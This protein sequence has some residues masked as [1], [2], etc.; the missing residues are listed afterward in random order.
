[1]L[2]GFVFS[3]AQYGYG[4]KNR[5]FKPIEYEIELRKQYLKEIKAY[6]RILSGK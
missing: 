4:I 1:M 2:I 5:Y 6:D 3:G